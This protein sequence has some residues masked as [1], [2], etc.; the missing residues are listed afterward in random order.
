MSAAPRSGQVA[1][2]YLA[3]AIGAAIGG[4][5]R[6][7][8]SLMMATSDWPW[9][10]LLAN[11]SGSLLIGL[12]SALP[13]DSRWS[14]GSLHGFVTAGFCGGLTTFSIFSLEVIQL[15][16]ADPLT[17]TGWLLLSLTAWLGSVS[18]GYFIGRSMLSA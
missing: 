1:A 5:G 4:G 18:V 3:V 9:P 17:A 11:V 12:Y 14:Q 2:I 7:L 6:H 16:A 15:M 13:A 10:T 8:I